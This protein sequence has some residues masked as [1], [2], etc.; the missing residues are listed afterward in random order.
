[1][2]QHNKHLLFHHFCESGVQIRL[3]SALCSGAI[4]L[5]SGYWSHC[6]V[7]WRLGWER[8]HFPNY[9][10]CWQ[11]ELPFGCMTE[12]PIFPLAVGCRPPPG[13][14]GCCGPLHLQVTMWLFTSSRQE[15]LSLQTARKEPYVM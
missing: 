3:S 14:R 10:G 11:N 4:K 15:N 13:P 9:S 8:I 7:I 6:V 12:D 1:M 5:K 2:G